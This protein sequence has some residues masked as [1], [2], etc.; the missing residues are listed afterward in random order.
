MS[1][2][3]GPVSS[4]KRIGAVG[5]LTRGAEVGGELQQPDRRPL[6]R[7]GDLAVRLERLFV[8][9]PHRLPARLHGHGLE[10]EIAALRGEH[11]G[12]RHRAQQRPGGD[13][14]LAHGGSGL[15]AD[16]NRLPVR[17]PRH[18][19]QIHAAR[20]AHAGGHGGGLDGAGDRID[21][22]AQGEE[23]A[24]LVGDGVVEIA[25]RPG[26][27]AELGCSTRAA[28]QDHGPLAGI[29]HRPARRRARRGEEKERDGRR[30]RLAEHLS[31][32]PS[33]AAN[34]NRRTSV[35]APTRARYVVADPRR[36]RAWLSRNG[37]G[38]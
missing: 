21:P 11:G 23:A 31:L 3:G 4:G 6:A 24:P 19:F 17:L 10:T 30:D 9:S 16:E 7:R 22:N 18:S 15:V 32:V 13:V 27:P 37:M 29:V 20:Q 1:R 35:D 2:P 12:E 36:R 34:H 25:A 28:A 33:R 38:C 14:V 8:G 26:Q 5:P